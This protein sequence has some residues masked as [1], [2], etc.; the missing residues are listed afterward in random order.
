MKMVIAN[1]NLLYCANDSARCDVALSRIKIKNTARR[2][3]SASRIIRLNYT[4]NII[5][6][7]DNTIADSNH[8]VTNG[9]YEMSKMARLE[10][11]KSTF[12]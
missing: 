11:P 4:L 5:M 1:G 8:F 10:I 12:L 2:I 3:V 6:A 7:Q 9:F